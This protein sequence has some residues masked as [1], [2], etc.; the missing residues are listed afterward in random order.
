MLNDDSDDDVGPNSENPGVD[1]NAPASHDDV[2]YGFGS[3]DI[4]DDMMNTE[5]NLEN[6]GVD[7]NAPAAAS[8]DDLEVDDIHAWLLENHQP[9]NTFPTKEEAENLG[10]T[11][12]KKYV[13]LSIPLIKR[14]D[15]QI[16]W[17]Y[18][19][20]VR[21]RTTGEI[22]KH[23]IRIP[24]RQ[25]RNHHASQVCEKLCTFRRWCSQ[26]WL[27][28]WFSRCPNADSTIR[29]CHHHDKFRQMCRGCDF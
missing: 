9:A 22:N 28:E 14:P 21:V 18:L 10:A 12:I 17:E 13:L 15:D 27:R 11:W 4:D 2:S 26:L 24:K 19:R 3:L 6:S 20:N 5:P 23:S 8:H 1:A 25:Q 16:V 7:A 29:E